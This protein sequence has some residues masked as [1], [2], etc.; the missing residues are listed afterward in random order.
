MKRVTYTAL[1]ILSCILFVKC[2]EIWAE[3]EGNCLLGD[4]VILW[5]TG[6]R[7]D[8]NVALCLRY[9]FGQ[10]IVGSEIIPGDDRHFNKNGEWSEYVD[11]A[12]AD[13]DWIIARTFSI[14]KKKK[15]YWIISKAYNIKGLDC[16]LVNC[17]SIIKSYMIGPMDSLDYEKKRNELHMNINFKH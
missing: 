6:N 13:K 12:I 2:K 8:W 1:L 7:Y 17:D 3:I 14:T 11:T 5:N 10:C 15:Y 16:H 9:S 4:R